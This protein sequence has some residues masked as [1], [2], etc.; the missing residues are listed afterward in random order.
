MGMADHVVKKPLTYITE[1]GRRAMTPEIWVA[2]SST[3]VAALAVIT[4]AMTARYSM[5][6]Q[7]DNLRLQMEE[8]S[9]QQQQDRLWEA[10]KEAF[11]GFLKWMH[12]DLLRSARAMSIG[13]IDDEPP[14][15]LPSNIEGTLYLVAS[16]GL[17]RKWNALRNQIEKTYEVAKK[18]A[19]SRA[20]DPNPE[21]RSIPSDRSSAL[22][23]D[24][25]YCS[26]WRDLE[27]AIR[28]DAGVEPL[29]PWT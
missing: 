27:N 21:Y 22:F 4:S 8:Q 18:E 14:T 3:A 23:G 25:R 7:S 12:D 29:F 11:A 13:K 5:K 24:I 9:R 6:Q 15:R 20:K 16:D 2:I 26:E 17:L 28:H 19:E 1:E 10:K